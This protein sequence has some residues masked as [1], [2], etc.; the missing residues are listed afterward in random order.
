MGAIR[1]GLIPAL[2][3]P[4][5]GLHEDQSQPALGEHDLRGTRGVERPHTHSAEGIAGLFVPVI[6]A[7]RRQDIAGDPSAYGTTATTGLR[8]DLCG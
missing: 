3:R 8:F 5:L 1:D 4:L 6:M 2:R 7:D